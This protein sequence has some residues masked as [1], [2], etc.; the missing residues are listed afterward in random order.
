M[1]YLIFITLLIFGYFISSQILERNK[2]FRFLAIVFSLY[3]FFT[4]WFNFLGI[5]VDFLFFVMIISFYD[6]VVSVIVLLKN[7]FDLN[8]ILKLL[9]KSNLQEFNFGFDKFL[10]ILVILSLLVSLL[11]FGSSHFG[12]QFESL[13][14]SL[15]YLLGRRFYEEGFIQYFSKSI[16]FPEATNIYSYPFGH[17][18]LLSL[19]FHVFPSMDQIATFNIFHIFFFV[20]IN[21]YFFSV[22]QRFLKFKNKLVLLIFILMQTLGF[23]FNLMIMGFTS[24]LVGL[25]FLLAAIDVYSSKKFRSH[26]LGVAILGLL[27]SSITTTYF[28]WLAIFGIFLLIDNLKSVLALGIKKYLNNNWKFILS[29]LF[30][31][32]IFSLHYL[33]VIFKSSMI[34]SAKSDGSSYK[35]FLSNF[36]LFLPLI[37][38]YFVSELRFVKKQNKFQSLILAVS[39]FVC[40]LGFFYVLNFIE[41]YTFSK[42]FYLFFPLIYAISLKELEKIR[43]SLNKIIYFSIIGILLIF[44]LLPFFETDPTY[45]QAN[46]LQLKFDDLNVKVFEIFHHNAQMTVNPNVHPVNA[47]AQKIEFAQSFQ[48]KKH[49]GKSLDKIVVVGNDS[50]S[51]WFY[52]LSDVFPR[53]KSNNYSVSIPPS[54]DYNAWIS[55]R[56]SDYLIFID[57][58]GKLDWARDNNFDISEFKV[59]YKVGDNYLLE[60]NPKVKKI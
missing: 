30:F 3:V 59:V 14:A 46:S 54:P 56:E 11:Y 23:F 2:V 37:I 17:T 52:S 20:L 9:I 34:A 27:V 60:Y 55:G 10:L 45:T 26:I 29:I 50:E 28:Y 22:V 43:D 40:V 57:N 4:F 47:S 8:K 42:S 16:F 7:S 18:V 12:P 51:L 1:I 48:H 25:F 58:K 39:V 36:I 6:V 41:P 21:S 15:H 53:D 5:C 32:V 13:D 44:V 35:I 38:N 33:L 24:Q 49:N 31:S 19:F